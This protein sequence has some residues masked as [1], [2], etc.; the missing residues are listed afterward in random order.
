MIDTDGEEILPY[1]CPNC[2][3]PAIGIINDKWC[4]ECWKIDMKHLQMLL[5]QKIHIDVI[6]IDVEFYLNYCRDYK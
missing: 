6:Y 2:K 3:K 5:N 1:T 4:L